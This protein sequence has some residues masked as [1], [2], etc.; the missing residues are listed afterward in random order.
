MGDSIRSFFYAEIKFVDIKARLL[1]VPLEPNDI[2]RRPFA[3]SNAISHMQFLDRS[4]KSPPHP[5]D[6]LHILPAPFLRYSKKKDHESIELNDSFLWNVLF[7]RKFV[8]SLVEIMMTR[9]IKGKKRNMSN[10]S[11]SIKWFDMRILLTSGIFIKLKFMN[12][13]S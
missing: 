12:S 2:V 6:T 8:A 1:S 3:H 13:F 7:K 10:L 4:W 9:R 5:D 11:G